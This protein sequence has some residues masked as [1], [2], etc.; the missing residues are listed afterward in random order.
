MFAEPDPWF[1]TPWSCDQPDILTDAAFELIAEGG[2]PAL[3]MRAIAG[4]TGMSPSWLTDRFTNRARMLAIIAQV[5]GDR[6]IAWIQARL[7][8]R[9]ALALLPSSD[10]EVVATRVWLALVE[11][12]RIEQGVAWRMAALRRADQAFVANLLGCRSDDLKV[13]E[14]IAVVDGLRAAIADPELPLRPRRAQ[15]ILRTY[16]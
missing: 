11:L 15:T 13:D 7:P 6:W 8:E 3:T 1:L 2:T 16:A 10:E 5:F 4:R 12:G 9:G 14:V